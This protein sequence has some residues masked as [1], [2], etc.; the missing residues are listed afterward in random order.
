MADG[1]WADANGIP[2]EA[3]VRPAWPGW[4]PAGEC[5]DSGREPLRPG[6]SSGTSAAAGSFRS[7][8]LATSVR[9]GIALSTGVCI[10]SIK[11][12]VKG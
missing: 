3:G 10:F 4:I 2:T 6:E 8:F 7:A 11:G 5:V 1:K 12:Q 9:A